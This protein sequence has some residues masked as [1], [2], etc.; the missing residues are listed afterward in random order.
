MIKTPLLT[1]ETV[2]KNHDKKL[3]LG[4]LLPMISLSSGYA[5]TVDFQEHLRNPD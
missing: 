4:L 2:N 5:W 1:N 3:F